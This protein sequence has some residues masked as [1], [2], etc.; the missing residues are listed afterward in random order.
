MLDLLCN[1]LYALS[2]LLPLNLGTEAYDRSGPAVL[3]GVPEAVVLENEH[4]SLKF[5][6][7]GKYSFEKF[8]SNGE[9]ILPDGGSNPDLWRIS[10]LGPRGE[11]PSITPRFSFYDGINSYKKADTS[12]VVIN[13][14]LLLEG[15]SSWA[16]KAKVSL[17]NDAELPEWNLS[18]ELPDGWIVTEVEFPSITFRKMS[19][20]K[21]ILPIGYGI[22]TDLSDGFVSECRYPSCIGAMQ[23][24]MVYDDE[25]TLY[26]SAKDKSASGKWLTVK[27]EK[28]GIRLSQKVTA[29][30]SWSDGCHFEIPWSTVAG[31]NKDSWQETALKWYRPF[32]ISTQWGAKSLKD[33]K[34]VKWISEADMWL[35]PM[36]VSEKT[37][38]ALDKALD[39]YGKGV[40]LHWYYWHN[41][42]FDTHYPD[43]FPA[44]KGFA[45][46]VSQ[47]QRKG[48]FVTPY[49]NGRLW[50]ANADSY[51]PDKGYEASCR[52]TDGTLYTEVY[53]SKVAN[54][55][56]CPTSSIWQD[57]LRTVSSR[58]L[59]ELGTDG[60]YFDQIAAAKDEACYAANHSHPKGGGSWWSEAYRSMINDFR[61]NIFGEEKAI[62]TEENAECYINMFDMLLIVNTPHATRQKIVPLFPLIYSDRCVYSGYTYIPYVI[63]DGS[64]RYISMMSLL[65][66][67]QLG[68]A[69][70]EALMSDK[71]RVEADFLKTLAK[72]RKK[73]RD[74]FFGG[75]FIKDFVP[76]GADREIAVPG[77]GEASEVMGAEWLDAAGKKYAVVVNMGKED[78]RISMNG[79]KYIVETLNV[80]RIKL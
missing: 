4:I 3:G 27:S 45:E 24:L 6:N 74:L 64:L 78:C 25:G 22:E 2:L 57:K 71:N 47:A 17:A 30:Y 26:Y 42:D 35:R 65:W 37:M 33:R 18:V 54:T 21:A 38:T 34:I 31:Y 77:Y 1:L 55:V 39:F 63:N 32:A 58:I 15:K 5:N 7:N 72:F 8:I 16:V 51:L 20:A 50:D 9:N 73:N 62:T 41:Y 40:G 12:I 29:S 68:W 67:S 14:R 23:L 43:Y 80:I 61:A 66:G 10:L 53:S 48:A 36:G 49:I 13:W 69:E 11:T 44:K 52:K 56:T 75:R 28:D 59:G 76:K 46:M 19:D 79:K 60:V 70:P